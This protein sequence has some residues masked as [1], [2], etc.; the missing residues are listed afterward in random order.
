MA[1]LDFATGS[2]HSNK[3]WSQK[4][5]REVLPKTLFG[6]FLGKGP[7][8]IAQEFE[9][10]TKGPGD[11]IYPNLEML[12]SGDGVSGNE[13][14]EGNETKPTFY[15]DSFVIN[16]LRQAVRYYGRMDQQRVVFKFRESA[17]AQLSDWWADRLDFVCLN[18]ACGNTVQTN[19]KYT[20]FN[21]TIKPDSNHHI[22]PSTYSDDSSI[23]SSDTFTLDLVDKA[24]TKAKTLHDVN[25]EPIIRPV[26]IAGGDYYPFVLHP[27]QWRDLRTDTSTGQWLDI[28]KAAM[29]GGEIAS[30]PIFTGAGGVY[31]G[32]VFFENTRIPLGCDDST[33]TTAVAST[34]R[35]V[36]LGAQ[37]LGVA[38]GREGGRP[39]RYLLNEESFDFG[40]ENGIAASLIFGV[41]KLRFNSADFGTM[42][43]SS[44]AAA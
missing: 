9:E 44:Y 16:Q 42:V 19:T 18:H 43:V 23:T 3:V 11:T 4:L 12:I 17:S 8:A 10:L 5:N 30:N 6:K 32:A 25:G 40:N 35:A 31:N 38:F 28:Q 27:Y 14:L 13:T 7:G 34:R 20:G 37:S 24:I 41:K 39:E 36:M 1:V 2:D 21:A 22:W 15:R 33:P 26:K 29:Q